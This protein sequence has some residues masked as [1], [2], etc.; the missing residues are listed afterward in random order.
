[1]ANALAGPVT[2][3]IVG[4]SG[5]TTGAVVVVVVV[6]VGGG[7]RWWGVAPGMNVQQSFVTRQHTVHRPG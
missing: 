1:M 7:S 5:I 3:H 6:G 4:T 2:E